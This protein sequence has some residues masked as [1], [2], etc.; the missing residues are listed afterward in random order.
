MSDSDKY[1]KILRDMQDL[2]LDETEFQIITALRWYGALNL[3]RISR[4]I[5]RPESTTLRFVRK[6]KDSNKIVFDSET[7]EKNWGNFYKLSPKVS[8]LYEAYMNLMD[9][10]VE[11]IEGEMQDIDKISD[12]DLEE[13]FKNEVINPGKLTEIPSTRAYFHFVFNLQKIMVNETMDG[14]IELHELAKKEGYD[15]IKEKV[16]LPP[17]DVTTYV[18]AMKVNKIRHVFRINELIIKFDRE[19]RQLG[20]ELIEEMDKEGIPEEERRIQFVNLF[21]GSLDIELKF[22]DS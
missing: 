19:L 21:T 15:E 10:R 17:I 20:K 2:E 1:L 6:M 22:K 4:L 9:Q 13:Y 12:E 5:Q 3:K 8:N 16:I 11:R 18:N 14:I 7:S